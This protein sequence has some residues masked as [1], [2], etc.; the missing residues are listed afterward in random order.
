MDPLSIVGLLLGIAAVVV[1]QYL[2]G[3]HLSMLVNGP[4]LLIVVGGTLGATMVQSPTHVFLR[5]L[6]MASW[7]SGRRPCRSSLR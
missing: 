7:I 1:G 3:G 5:A 6:R 2:E 4:A